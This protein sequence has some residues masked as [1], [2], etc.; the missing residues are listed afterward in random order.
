MLCDD[1]GAAL[2]P[3]FSDLWPI[4]VLVD[5]TDAPGCG[6]WHH[7]SKGKPAGEEGREGEEEACLFTGAGGS[8]VASVVRLNS[9]GSSTMERMGLSLEQAK[10]EAARMWEAGEPPG[11]AWCV[12]LE[13]KEEEEASERPLPLGP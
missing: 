7:A 4:G 9:G 3:P 12:R 10:E 6:P 1:E 8:S 2:A 5:L 13:E 11:C